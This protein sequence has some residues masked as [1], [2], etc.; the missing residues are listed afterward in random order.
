MSSAHLFVWVHAEREI[1][2]L[3]QSMYCKRSARKI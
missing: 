1:E 2:W 3:V